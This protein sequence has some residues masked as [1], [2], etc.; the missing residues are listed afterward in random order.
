MA[1][2][3]YLPPTAGSTIA[4]ETVALVREAMGDATRSITMASGL[5]GYELE[6][7]A[8]VIVP[9][10][11]PLVNMLPRRRGGGTDIVHWKAITSFDTSRNWGVLSDGGTPAQ[12]TYAVASL[13]NTM[14]AIGLMNAVSF[15]AQWRG[16][17][18]ES[19]VRAR[20]IAEL[21]YQLKMTEERWL[22]GASTYLLTPPAPVVASATTGGTIAA[23]TYWVKVTAKNAQGETTG[24]SATK[25][26][27]TGTTSTLTI[28]VFTVP[29]ATQYNVYIGSGASLPADSAL[30]L[31]A[32]ISGTNAQQPLIGATV[33]LADGATVMPSGEV[34]PAILPLT[35]SAPPATT[36]TA[37]STVAAN[38]AK[39]FID[40]AGSPLMWDGIIAQALNNTSLANGATLGAQVAQP[41][42][43]AGKLALADIDNLLAGMYLQA[44]GDPD[45]II[46]NPLDNVRLTNLVVGAGQLRYVVQAGDS[47]DQGQL[48]AQYRVTRYLNKSTGREIPIILDRYCPQGYM[49]FLPMTV[50]FPVPEVS[51][52]IEI[53]TNQEYWGVDFAVTDSNFRF[54]DYVDETVKVY[55]LG[56][57]GVIRGIYPSF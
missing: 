40:G 18:L 5:V 9:V 45:Y 52:A 22:L 26:V 27:T 35:L 39:T 14:Q 15:Q 32:G 7:P 23:G 20:R 21:L 34:N 33:T 4:D 12:V 55:F 17:R 50:P 46:M 6:T 11:T 16:R 29:N 1:S 51:S 37:L 10:I 13:Q 8:K 3:V 48:T 36:G 31:Q 42:D 44:A 30:W 53:E 49:V 43:P 56:G 38:T 19:D 28:T 41:A 47:A 24:S 2:A 57:L 54:A 25:I